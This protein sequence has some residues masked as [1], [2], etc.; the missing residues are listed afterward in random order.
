MIITN[1]QL[2]SS[3]ELEL[4]MRATTLHGAPNSHPFEKAE[5]TLRY[6]NPHNLVPT[7]AFVLQEQ[8]DIIDNIYNQMKRNSV[9]IFNLLGFVTYKIDNSDT[10]FTFT[11][12]IIEIIDKQPLIIDGQHRTTY[13]M[14]NNLNMYALVID[15]VPSNMLPYQMPLTGGWQSVK[16]FESR[17]PDGFVRKQRRYTGDKNKYF[18]REYPFPGVIK[19]AREHT[20]R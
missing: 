18:F 19:I 13:A 17:L 4:I 8:I 12:P 9:D 5:I 14:Q 1:Y 2:H 6:V 7:Q 10:Q 15:R 3:R 20:G 11:P 16:C